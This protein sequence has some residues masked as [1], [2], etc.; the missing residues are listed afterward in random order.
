MLYSNSVYSMYVAPPKMSDEDH[1]AGSPRQLI[2]L[3]AFRRSVTRN[4]A[5]HLTTVFHPRGGAHDKKLNYSFHSP[6]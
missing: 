4:A 5:R 2:L 3:Q 6:L 1:E